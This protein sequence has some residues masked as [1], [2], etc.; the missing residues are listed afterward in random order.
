MVEGGLGTDSWKPNAQGSGAMGRWQLLG[1][2]LKEYL[3]E[4]APGDDAAQTRYVLRKL[5][6]IMPGFSASADTAAQVAAITKFES[7]GKPP[8]YYSG[9]LGAARKLVAG[10]DVP[11]ERPPE[12]T[13]ASDAEVYALAQRIAGGNPPT[14]GDLQQAR[15]L[16]GMRRDKPA[17][18]KYGSLDMVRS[19]QLADASSRV[20]TTNHHHDYGD[21]NITVNAPARDGPAIAGAISDELSRVQLA[22][23][24]NTGLG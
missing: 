6:E 17:G 1:D 7:S 15:V 10:G 18:G 21:N 24:A 13:S 16:L 20:T 8:S 23:R 4:G 2:K 9:G 19:Y 11:A 22:N 5:N 14:S 12:G 3:E